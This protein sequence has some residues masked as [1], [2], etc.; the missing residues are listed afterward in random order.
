MTGRI[1]KGIGSFY[2]IQAEDNRVYECKAR[3]IFRKEKIIPMI[4]D[5]VEIDVKNDK[6]SITKIFKRKNSLVRP[7]V[8]NIDTLVIVAAARSPE[9]NLPLIDKMTVNA[10][11]EGIEPIICINK[12]DLDKRDDLYKIYSEAGYRVI[13]TS[14]EENTGIDELI[15][16]IKDKVSAFSGMS[17]VGKS[18]LLNLITGNELE[19]GSVSEKIQRGRHTTRHVELMELENGG[20]VLDTPGFGSLEPN[21]VKANELWQYFPEMCG[22][23]GGCKFRG[24]MHINEPDCAVKNAV[25]H[26]SIAQSRYESYKQIFEFLKNIKEWK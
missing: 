19:T 2:Y 16:V 14:A 12:S 9:P 7:P 17:G 6:G 4:G 15:D 24:C 3:G 13:R 22:Y 11:I 25:M 10:H 18:S 23:T 20:Y 5:T 21:I 26:G 8:A 1:I